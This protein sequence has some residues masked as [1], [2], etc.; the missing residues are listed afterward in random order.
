MTT[1][2]SSPPLRPTDTVQIPGT[3]LDDLLSALRRRDA[4]RAGDLLAAWSTA[5]I[6]VDDQVE[7]FE[8]DFFLLL[9]H[10]LTAWVHAEVGLHVAGGRFEHALCLVEAYR[11]RSTAADMAMRNPSG[12]LPL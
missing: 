12:E 6:L 9:D 8:P 3:L 5:E 4:A 1:T 7:W 11:P 10:P 2:I